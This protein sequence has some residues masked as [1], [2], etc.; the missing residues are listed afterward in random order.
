MS[1]PGAPS[2]CPMCNDK[3]G[4]GK[5]VVKEVWCD[6]YTILQV[7]SVCA[8]EPSVQEMSWLQDLLR[9]HVPRRQVL[10]QDEG[11]ADRELQ[12]DVHDV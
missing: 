9:H 3:T 4:L 5:P 10:S 6:I 12:A 2:P 8:G 1:V 7:E 11:R